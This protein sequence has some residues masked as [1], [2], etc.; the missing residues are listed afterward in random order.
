MLE[1]A[2]YQVNPPERA[3][4]VRREKSPMEQFLHHILHRMLSRSNY[5]KC[6]LLL[7]KMDWQDTEVWHLS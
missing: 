1:S 7:R 6:L 4:I 3:A 5:V 2:Y